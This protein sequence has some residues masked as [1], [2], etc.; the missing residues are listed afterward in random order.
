MGD[1]GSKL[2]GGRLSFLV[3]FTNNKKKQLLN[4]EYRDEHVSELTYNFCV[5]RFCYVQG[6]TPT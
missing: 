2:T 1:P 3:M 5:Q 4:Y 6:L